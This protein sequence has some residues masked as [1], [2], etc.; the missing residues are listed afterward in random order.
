MRRSI[1]LG[2]DRVLIGDAEIVV[3]VVQ[4][5]VSTIAIEIRLL[6]TRLVESLCLRSGTSQLVV[7]MQSESS[8][9]RAVVAR[10]QDQRWIFD[11]APTQIDYLESRLLHAFRD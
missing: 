3:E 10:V 5:R 2:D 8:A 1:D 9:T 4:S 6:R 7:R 11:L